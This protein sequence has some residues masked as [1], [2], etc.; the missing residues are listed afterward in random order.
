MHDTT[1]FRRCGRRV[2]WTADWAPI[3]CLMP[4]HGVTEP[5]Q[6]VDADGQLRTVASPTVLARHWL[7]TWHGQTIQLPTVPPGR[8]VG[9]HRREAPL[10]VR[11]GGLI[12]ALGVLLAVAGGVLI[13]VFGG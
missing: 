13:G 4:P 2:G 1:E 8:F 3:T 6:Y 7:D 12:L 11:A 9:S 10:F 5:C